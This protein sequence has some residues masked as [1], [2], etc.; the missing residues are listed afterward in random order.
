MPQP[1]LQLTGAD[2]EQADDLRAPPQ[3][4][5]ETVLARE[6]AR[7]ARLAGEFALFG[8]EIHQTDA[9]LWVEPADQAYRAGP[10]AP[11]APANDACARPAFTFPDLSQRGAHL[12]PTMPIRFIQALDWLVVLATA[13]LA[14][15]WGADDF[16]LILKAGAGQ[17]L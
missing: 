12:A 2:L 4:A 15:R 7:L 1:A 8:L 17:F 16:A 9:S 6:A 14:A 13:E 11:P 10:E 5:A 3:E